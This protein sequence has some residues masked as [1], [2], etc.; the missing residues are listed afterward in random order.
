MKDGDEIDEEVYERFLKLHYNPQTRVQ[1]LRMFNK[2]VMNNHNLLSQK[3]IENYVINKRD[4]YERLNPLY[5]GFLKSYIDCFELPFKIPKS[6]KKNQNIKKEYK[7]ITKDQID[8]LIQHAPLWVSLLVEL[9]FETGLRLRELINAKRQDIDLEE[10]TISGMGKG[11]KPF[12]VRFGK[13][14]QARLTK[15]LHNNERE[16]PLHIDDT[17]KD[18]PRKFWYELRKAGKTI[19]DIERLHPHRLRH[20]LG[21][22]LRADKSLD[23]QQIKVKLRHSKLETTDIYTEA[24]QEEVDDIIDKEVFENG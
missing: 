7:F 3:Q 16:F 2:E 23:L 17:K 12:K 14:S 10:R 9:Y 4:Q 18:W 6:R 15:W 19:L 22:H 5:S 24:T 1:Y 11:N 8:K 20:A 13:K 21:H